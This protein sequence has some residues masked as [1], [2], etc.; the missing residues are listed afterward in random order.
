MGAAAIVGGAGGGIWGGFC[1]R[2][3]ISSLKSAP[4]TMLNPISTKM[5]GH[6][7]PR[8]NRIARMIN[9]MPPRKPHGRKSLG[10]CLNF[11]CLCISSSFY[12]EIT[13]NHTI[14]Y[15]SFPQDVAVIIRRHSIC[16]DQLVS[17]DHGMAFSKSNDVCDSN[18]I[19]RK[20][21]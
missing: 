16:L 5:P 19:N 21:R 15:V 3:G 20:E 4:K 11:L 2:C 13:P 6:Q 1:V 10:P 8:K 9:Q 18:K 14:V 17:F 12:K 7:C